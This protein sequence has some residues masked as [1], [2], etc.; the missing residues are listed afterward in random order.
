MTRMRLSGPSDMRWSEVCTLQSW[1]PPLLNSP[2]IQSGSGSAAQ[3]ILGHDTRLPHNA[4]ANCCH[5]K[6]NARCILQ[7]CHGILLTLHVASHPTHVKQPP[8]PYVGEVMLGSGTPWAIRSF[9]HTGYLG[10]IATSVETGH[11]WPCLRNRD[12]KRSTYP[13]W[14]LTLD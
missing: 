6:L 2:S 13:C 3:I 5:D 7:T 12:V 11:G 8:G 9:G 14:M 1:G 10:H 4:F